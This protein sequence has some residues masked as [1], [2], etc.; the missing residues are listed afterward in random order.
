[1]AFNVALTLFLAEYSLRVYAAWS[2]RSL[3]VADTIDAYKLVPGHDYGGGLRGNKASLL[4]YHVVWG[5]GA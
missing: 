2:E 3:L 5:G 1:V 4:L